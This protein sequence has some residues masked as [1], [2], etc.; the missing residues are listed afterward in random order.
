MDAQYH[1]YLRDEKYEDDEGNVLKRTD[2]KDDEL[3]DKPIIENQYEDLALLGDSQ[4]TY[5]DIIGHLL[6]EEAGIYRHVY[7][8]QM[9]NLGLK[10]T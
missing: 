10:N 3:I 9:K 1:Q 4:E 2:D 5:Q 6:E 8:G 7:M